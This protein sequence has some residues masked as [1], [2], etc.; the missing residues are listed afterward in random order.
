MIIFAT[1][2]PEAKFDETS[3]RIILNVR[4]GSDDV[5]VSLSIHDATALWKQLE[6]TMW[7]AHNGIRERELSEAEIRPFAGGGKSC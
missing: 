5:G 4:S 1:G 7:M 6:R 3:D 2:S